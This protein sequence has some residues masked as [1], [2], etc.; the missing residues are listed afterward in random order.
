[1]P[2][3]KVAITRNNVTIFSQEVEVVFF[4]SSSCI[5]L[6]ILFVSLKVSHSALS[7]CISCLIAM[8]SC[9]I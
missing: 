7:F 4:I 9:S 6:R 2:D 3:S 1:M 5:S 8:R